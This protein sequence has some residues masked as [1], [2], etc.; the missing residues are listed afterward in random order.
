MIRLN[1]DTLHINRII[2]DGTEGVAS[3]DTLVI[4]YDDSVRYLSLL[5]LKNFSLKH[6]QKFDDETLAEWYIHREE[7]FVLYEAYKAKQIPITHDVYE[8]FLASNIDSKELITHLESPIF[9]S[10]FSLYKSRIIRKIYMY[11]ESQVITEF[12][13]FDLQSSNVPNLN[14][15]IMIIENLDS[16][17]DIAGKGGTTYICD[18]ST[19]QILANKCH[20]VCHIVVNGLFT[21]NVQKD[22]SPYNLE[23]KNPFSTFAYMMPKLE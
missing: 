4:Q 20:E 23:L 14:N 6:N 1:T 22:G 15:E 11:T 10:I 19:A 8:H 3:G 7:K 17:V 5:A 2:S 13:S 12:C 21:Y 16:I 18:I 9:S